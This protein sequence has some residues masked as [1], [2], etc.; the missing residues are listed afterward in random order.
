MTKPVLYGFGP[1]VWA[2]APA[3][4]LVALGYTADDID[5]KQVN[6]AEGENFHPEFL[7]IN[8]HGTLPTLVEPN[9]HTI[10]GTTK[11]VIEYLIKHAPK[12]DLAGKPSGT[13]LIHKLH[14]EAVDPNFAFLSFRNDAELE[15]KAKSFAAV[16]TAQRQ[17][18]LEKLAPT[19]PPQFAEFYKH[20][21]AQNGY[22]NNIFNGTATEG[23]VIVFKKA[24]ALWAGIK[25]FVLNS[26][27]GYLPEEEGKFIGGDAPGEDDFHLIAWLGRIALVNGGKPDAS[28]VDAIGNALEGAAVPPKVKA[29]WVTWTKTQAFQK[30]YV[31]GLR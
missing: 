11:S 21:I 4:A 7:K 27:P 17:A 31:N 16:F 13:D 19:S 18:T 3:I 2:T 6:L 22:I 5:E 29:Y 30:V 28:G 12:A 14:S 15:A 25:D 9:G 24:V 10:H 20:K 23:K 1:S 26:L 8:S